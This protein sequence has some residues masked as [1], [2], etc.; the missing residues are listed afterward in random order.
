MIRV[1]LSAT[2]GAGGGNRTRGHG[3]RKPREE[4]RFKLTTLPV[5]ES[6]GTQGTMQYWPGVQ[7]GVRI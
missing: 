4:D 7:L 1:N 5:R 3:D 2:V 6:V